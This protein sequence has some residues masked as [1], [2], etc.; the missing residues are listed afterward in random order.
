[1]SKPILEGIDRHTRWSITHVDPLALA[2]WLGGEL[3]SLS[4]DVLMARDG[5][6]TTMFDRAALE[7]LL[8]GAHGLDPARWS[9]RVWLLLMLG[10][11]DRCVHKEASKTAFAPSGSRP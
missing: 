9:R 8:R 3:R 10:L 2:R 4:E 11:W 6:L 7:R 1:M 5:L